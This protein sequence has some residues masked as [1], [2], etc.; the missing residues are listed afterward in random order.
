M[1]NFF[2]GFVAGKNSTIKHVVKHINYIRNITGVDH[3]GLG[4]DFNGVSRPTAGLD[5]VSKYPKL[6]EALL[7]DQTYNWTK[8]DLAKLANINIIRVLREV[9]TIKNLLK[10][11]LPNQKILN[12]PLNGTLNLSCSSG[13][14][15]LLNSLRS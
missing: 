2:E 4:A 5:D 14:S 9:E 8:E 7:E 10:D 1:I 12:N 6:F 11:R 13:D 3:I 15:F